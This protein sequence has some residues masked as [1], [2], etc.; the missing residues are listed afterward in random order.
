MNNQR[1]NITIDFLFSFVLVMGFSG[2]LFAMTLTLTAVEITQYMTYASARNYMASHSSQHKQRALAEE[3]FT[4]LREHSVPAPLFSNGWFELGSSPV[5]GTNRD[6][7]DHVLDHYLFHGT[8]V[9]FQAHILDF[10]IPFFG[11]TNANGGGFR[12]EIGSYL[13][14]E[15]S[16][17]DCIG[18]TQKRWEWIRQIYSGGVYPNP[19]HYKAF[20]DNGC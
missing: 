7:H 15:V 2:L 6:Y 11:S 3:K 20:T 1:G 4:K 18:F 10:K 19:H 8:W 5:V 16:I 14:I 13:G 12:T 9:S 17:E